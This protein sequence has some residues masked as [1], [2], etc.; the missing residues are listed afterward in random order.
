MSR[1]RLIAMPSIDDI[2]SNVPKLGARLFAK[3]IPAIKNRVN[4]KYMNIVI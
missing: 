4:T 2:D 3:Y 1:S